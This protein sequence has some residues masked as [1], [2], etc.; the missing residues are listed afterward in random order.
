MRFGIGMSTDH[1]PEEVG[2]RFS[3]GAQAHP[4]DRGQGAAQAE[5]PVAEP[6]LKSLLDN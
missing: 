1:T 6:E 5:A 2:R 3:G 4:P